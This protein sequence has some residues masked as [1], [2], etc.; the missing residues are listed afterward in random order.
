MKAFA[1]EFGIR[2]A[3]TGKILV[4]ANFEE[5]G[6]LKVIADRATTN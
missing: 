1:S 5:L 4:A 3:T 2:Y 6:G